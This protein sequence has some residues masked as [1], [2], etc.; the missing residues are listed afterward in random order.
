MVFHCLTRMP[1]WGMSKIG[2]ITWA[3]SARTFIRAEEKSEVPV[4]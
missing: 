3:P 1:L 4:G 2:R